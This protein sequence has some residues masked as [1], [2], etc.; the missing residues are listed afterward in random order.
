MINKVVSYFLEQGENPCSAAQA[1]QSMEM[2]EQFA[3]GGLA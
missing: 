1:I 3:Y 2:M